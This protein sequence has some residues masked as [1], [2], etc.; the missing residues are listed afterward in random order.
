MIPLLA[1]TAALTACSAS[2]E[3]AAT[4]TGT[5]DSPQSGSSVLTVQDRPR[6]LAEAPAMPSSPPESELRTRLRRDFESRTDT[7]R[8]ASPPVRVGSAWRSPSGK[9]ITEVFVVAR[10]RPSEQDGVAKTLYFSAEEGTYWVFEGGGISGISRWYGP[11][12]LR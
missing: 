9:P 8:A 1:L 5:P 6:Q 3:P 11:F 7:P 4:R 2:R 12:T 10:T